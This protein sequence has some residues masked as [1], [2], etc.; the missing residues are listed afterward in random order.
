MAKL[1]DEDFRA[2]RREFHSNV[3]ARLEDMEDTLI[4]LS[5][6]PTEPQAVDAL[7]ILKFESHR[8]RGSGGS[9][10][11]PEMSRVAGEMEDYLEGSGSDATVLG[12]LLGALRAAV[13]GDEDA[14][15]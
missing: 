1:D 14:R 13:T 9:F 5:R 6:P 11:Y 4:R 3:V 7:G 15:P 10:G 8:L 2:L 12:R